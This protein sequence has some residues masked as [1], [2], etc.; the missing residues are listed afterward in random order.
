MMDDQSST[1]GGPQ[2]G[3]D[4]D[5]RQNHGN[6]LFVGNL[7]FQTP[8]QHVKDHFRKAGKVRYTDLIAD[9]MGRPKG[10][11]LVTMVTA[12]G[13]Q[14]AIRMYNETD[15]EGRRL[16]VRLFD[17]GPRPPIVQRGM[18][19]QYDRQAQ[20]QQP[21]QQSQRFRGYT[22]ASSGGSNYNSTTNFG[23]RAD[24]MGRGGYTM[25]ED[26]NATSL[27]DMGDS[28]PKPRSQ[29]VNE[30]GRKLFV[31]NLPF[32]CTSSALRE[33]F[34]QVGNV[35]RAEVILGRN[36]KSR[37]MGIV[38]MRTEKE[39]RLAIEEFDGIEMANRAM[40]V[41]LDNKTTA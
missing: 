23:R 21:Q 28:V 19:P 1:S 4:A 5:H 36:G 13:A 6:V 32:D 38:V 8:W 18:M 11:A 16:I 10:S 31:S 34:Q 35:E 2:E 15:F 25:E 9:R 24:Y 26:L 37:G 41:R 17:D 40:S 39:T 27:N 3:R 12:E 20:Q 29:Q 14:R 30:F 33:T 7:P 22:G